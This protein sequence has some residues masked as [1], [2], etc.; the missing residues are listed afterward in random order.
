MTVYLWG[1]VS[2]NH[3][4]FW[5]CF[6]MFYQAGHMQH[7]ILVMLGSSCDLELEVSHAVTSVSRQYCTTDCIQKRNDLVIVCK[8]SSCALANVSIPS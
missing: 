8:L 5:V 2:R 7:S 6:L 1:A 3:H 4:T